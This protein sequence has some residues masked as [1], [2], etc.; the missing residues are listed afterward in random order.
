MMDDPQGGARL[1][2]WLARD[3]RE[4]GED[5]TLYCYG[6]DQERC[7]PDVLAD[8][9][10]RCVRR[11]RGTAR[12][13]AENGWRRTAIQL[14]RYFVETPALAALLDPRTDVINPHEWLAHRS[15]ALVGFRRGI[16]IVWTYNDPSHWHIH[17]GWGPRE[18]PYRALGWFDTRQVNRFAA[19]TTLSQW[20]SEVARRSFTA[21]IEIVRCGVDA[22]GV[23]P[24]A[25]SNGGGAALQLV[26]VG[27]LAPW[28]RFE[29]AIRAVALAWRGGL[30]CRYEIIGSDRFW[31]SYGARL[32]ELVAELGLAETVA[33]RFESVTEAE[34]EAAYERA[35][36][37]VFPN[38][39]QAWGLAQLETM[40]RGVPTV[41]SRGA[42]VSEVLRDGETALLVDTRQ[43]EQIARAI[44]RLAQDPALRAQLAQRGRAFV[45]D[46]YTSM[47]YA[48]QMRDV[49]RR[50]I[51]GRRRAS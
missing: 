1:I 19:V 50:C 37:A 15:A 12:P 9:P 48:H 16:P 51:A 27:I 36:V 7:F 30:H 26:S 11:V 20:M 35:D 5:V 17:S 42:G 33:L 32:R 47:H 25:Q 4:L 21:P 3:L 18:L 6:F 40:V 43:P 23:P 39:S 29:D 13:V 2:A 24:P 44:A 38:E 14:R 45:L 28:R 22:R 31:P 8:V 10:V 41:V 34:L 46:S 49:F